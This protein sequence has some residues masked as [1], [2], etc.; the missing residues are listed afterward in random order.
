MVGET[1]V[2]G[3]NTGSISPMFICI[4]T[5]FEFGNSIR[6]GVTPGYHYP[7]ERNINKGRRDHGLFI[8]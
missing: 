5:E 2:C 4:G 7:K 8:L 6:S 3:L 1:A